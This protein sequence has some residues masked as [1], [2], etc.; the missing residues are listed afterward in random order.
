[1]N[2]KRC[3][4]PLSPIVSLLFVTVLV[5]GVSGLWLVQT[6]HAADSLLDRRELNDSA[7]PIM[8][9]EVRTDGYQASPQSPELAFCDGFDSPTLDP[10]WQVVAFTGARVYG[11]TSPANHISLVDNPGHLRYYVDEMT[12]A[13]GFLNNYQV[14][15]A[16]Y[17]YDFGLELHRPFSGEQWTLDTKADYWLPYANGRGENV[18]VYFGDGGANTFVVQIQRYRDV[19]GSYNG[20]SIG[21]LEKFGPT[22]D[23]L[24]T[25]ESYVSYEDIYGPPAS[26][27][28]YRLE[29]NGSILTASWSPDGVA[30]TEAF[31]RDMG[32]Q[33]DGLQQRVV[34]TGLSW[35]NPVGSFADYD[36]VCLA[37]PPTVQFSH[38]NYG[39][40]EGAG[41][42]LITATLS[43]VSPYA[44]TVDYASTDGTALAG[45]D[46]LTAS[47]TLTFTPG[48]TGQT[49]SV[50]ILDDEID[51][52][53]E[54]VSLT[55]SGPAGAVLGVP[56]TAVLTIIDDNDA[57]VAAD[58]TF[59]VT[60]D[61]QANALTVLVNDGDP[62]LNPLAVSGVGVP[63]QGGTAISAGTHII[64]TP[65][66]D[67]YGL[68]TFAYT[69]F[70]G[71]GG[72]D[73]A[74]VTVTVTPN[75]RVYLPLVFRNH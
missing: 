19:A 8:A 64:Y 22:L 11:Y 1:M 61:S 58:D 37:A 14:H 40:S 29:R 70:D 38:G 15:V 72:Y 32:S 25:L 41:T 20:M 12:Y 68:E 7:S 39:V 10:A 54:T 44:V 52:P 31:S 62:E 17:N 3:Y 16:Y 53:T 55:L 65:A 34:I 9:T 49:F 27:Y 26:T 60:E 28:F 50:P 18:H 23:D 5:V 13:L 24:T 4:R 2:T 46:C 42:A 21:L 30:W 75:Y 63:N 74:T 73:S 35:F 69:V 57:P 71:Q 48:V 47:G 59:T 56:V 33:L 67:F 66:P 36:Y 51:E 6:N 45:S 43:A